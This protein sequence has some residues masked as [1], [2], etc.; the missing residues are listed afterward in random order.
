MIDASAENIAILSQVQ[1][2]YL[3][4]A[5]FFTGRLLPEPHPRSSIR[6]L[7]DKW[8]QTTRDWEMSALSLQ[9]SNCQ[10]Q[11]QLKGRG[12][13]EIVVSSVMMADDEDDQLPSNGNCCWWLINHCPLLSAM[14]S[15]SLRSSE[16]GLLLV[17]FART[18]TKQSRAFSVVGP[19]IWNGLPS[20]LRMLPR[21]LSPAF[22]LT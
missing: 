12:E 3:T 16:Q 9:I 8:Q 13:E 20:Q 21:A 6:W 4:K 10:R 2:V 19:S 5:L 11:S 22:F 15:R 14:S 17:S 1:S 7:R 18:S